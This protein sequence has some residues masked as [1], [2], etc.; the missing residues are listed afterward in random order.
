M[1]KA[2]F[3][4]TPLGRI[5]IAEE[6]G[7]ITN[8]F[9]GSTV[10]PQKYITEETELLKK[11]G[12]QLKEYFAG[13]R[14][15]FDLPVDTGGTPFQKEVWKALTEIPYGQICSYQD[16]ARRIGRPKACRAVGRANGTN[17]VA[18]LVPCHRVIGK[19]GTL[20]GYAGGLDIKEF[21]L[22]LEKENA[23]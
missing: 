10:T 13:T 3:Y 9:F 2:Y 23:G 19:S 15:E 11:A 6:D 18:I 8:L 21:L 20:T 5:G 16:I 4:D 14:K 1:K 7:K 17:P 22:K 12:T